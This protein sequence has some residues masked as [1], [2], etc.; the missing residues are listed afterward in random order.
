MAASKAN[1]VIVYKN[2]SQVYSA[3]N[4]ATAL[5]T[6]LPK[7]CKLEDKKILFMSFLPDEETLSVYQLK[8][9]DLQEEESNEQQEQE[10]S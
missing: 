3:T 4:L 2:S 10:N 7:G 8:N 9:E 6:P 5:K 1:Y